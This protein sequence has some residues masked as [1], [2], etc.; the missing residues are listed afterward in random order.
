[1]GIVRD[2]KWLIWVLLVSGLLVC[3]A[4]RQFR[5]EPD[6]AGLPGPRPGAMMMSLAVGEALRHRVAGPEILEDREVFGPAE[7]RVGGLACWRFPVIYRTRAPLGGLVLHR[8]A[9]WVRDGRVIK[10]QW[11]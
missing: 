6:P 4:A 2:R 8:G 1:M 5:P 11:D 7:D 10:E 9:L 3:G